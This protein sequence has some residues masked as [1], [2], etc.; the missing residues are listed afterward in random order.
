VKPQFETPSSEVPQGGVIRD[1]EAWRAAIERVA[2]AC[3][4]VG[5]GA[6]AAM[7]SPIRGPAGNVEFLL[8]AR[9]GA[10]PALLDGAAVVEEV[11]A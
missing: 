6:L 3:D 7:P 2:A 4:A 10:P 9:A 1:R 8:H 11:P 5:A